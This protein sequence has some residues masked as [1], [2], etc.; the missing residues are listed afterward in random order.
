MK[1]ATREKCLLCGSREN[2]TIFSFISPDKYEASVGVGKKNYSR[3]WVRC[4]KCGFYY[5]IYS[6][7][8]KIL[9]RIYLSSYRDK[10]S[11]WKGETPEETFKKI[12]SLP[13]GKSETKFRVNWVKKNIARLWKHG[14]VKKNSPPY[15][16]LDIGGGAGVFAYEFKDANWAPYIV[17]PSKDISFLKTRLHIPL[18]QSFYKPRRFHCKF[19]L[20]S[21][22]YILEHVSNPLR[23]LKSARQDMAKN[24]FLYIEVPDALSFRLKPPGDDIFNSCHLWMFDPKSMTTL[25][26]KCRYEIFN[27]ERLQTK[28]GHYSLMVLAGLK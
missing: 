19:T 18:V 17:D 5:S 23:F 6:R 16:A 13:P 24:S 9:D 4:K 1:S 27:M 2:K 28:R 26:D 8:G 10:K 3:K 22:I 11:S 20:V 12:I 25:L 21:L 15:R 7:P 14:L